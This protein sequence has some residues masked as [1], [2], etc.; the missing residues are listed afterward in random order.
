[1]QS[2]L[3]IYIES[4]LIK[5][6]KVSRDKDSIKVEAFN[7][8]FFENL[9]EALNKI[10]QETNSEK[11]P[12]SINI[13][14]E[15]YNYFDVFSMLS[16]QDA[17]KAVDI[18]FETFCSSKQY[19]ASS[20]ETRFAL[21]PDKEDKER[22]NVIHI[23]TNKMDISKKL[24]ELGKYK[25]S[26]MMPIS[27]SI[28]NLIEIKPNDNIAIINIEDQ[29]KI[30]II[31]DGQIARID[32]LEE[33]MGAILNEINQTENSMKKTYEICKNMT[34]YGDTSESSDNDYSGYTV[35][36][37]YKMVTDCKKIIEESFESINQIYITGLGV[38]INNID[39]Y[40]QEYFPNSK[41]ELLKPFFVESASVNIPVKEYL[42]VNSAIALALDGVGF[43]NKELDFATSISVGI[44]LSGL[45]NLF[46]GKKLTIDGPMQ[47]IEKLLLRMITSAVIL[48]VGF[49]SLSV[50]ITNRIETETEKV[51]AALNKSQTEINKIETD[52]N[53]IASQNAKYTSMID[54]IKNLEQTSQSIQ[55]G[56]IIEKYSIPN[57]L[58]KIGNQIPEQVTLIEIY[59]DEKKHIVI[60]AESEK[61]EQLGYFK[62]IIETKGI[63]TNVK[64]T[65]GIK[66]VTDT[67]EAKENVVIT[68]V[69]EGDLP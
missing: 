55:A 54:S 57:L 43:K 15:L 7:V 32:V 35:S 8:E 17:K 65:S 52:I 61:Y 40:F 48:L 21:V 36:A 37:L 5:Y 33:G 28:T 41:C 51:D 49:I 11:I 68:I 22:L 39:L 47:A 18:E 38:V 58:T 56:R 19:N 9:G 44:D 13:S 45:K 34:I 66:E 30:T 46:A 4:N 16:K 50:F 64:A 27:T 6:A 59:N 31:I 25:V 23:A 12:I 20:L 63:L 14:N 2:C 62:A 1:M 26:S 53:L 29:V 24:K 3:G 42:E 67:N 60:K 10:I 69:I